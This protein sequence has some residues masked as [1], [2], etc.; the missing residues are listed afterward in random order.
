[1]NDSF[2][3]L[4]LCDALLQ[5]LPS[6]DYT[7]MT[8]IQAQS[9]PI[10]LK[11]HDIIAK[12]KT[13][14]GKTAAFGLVLLNALNVE[15][16]EVQ[17]LVLCPTRELAEQVSQALR[18][19]AR[20]IPNVKIFTLCGG[21]PSKSQLDSLKHGVHIIVGTPGR[22]QKHLDQRSLSLK[23]LQILV[24]DEMDKMLDMGFLDDIKTIIRSCP[25]QRQTLMFSATISQEIKNIAVE[26]MKEPHEVQIETAHSEQE[27]YQRFYEIKNQA[28]KFPLLKAILLHYQPS[29]SLIFCN[30]KQQTTEL[31]KM[32]VKEG[33]SAGALHGD[34]TQM[35]RDEAIICFNN[36]SCPIIVATDIA[37]RGIDIKE[38][39]AVINFELAF[40]HDVHIH[41]IG[42]TGRAGHKG[43][44]FSLV[45]PADASLIHAIGSNQ[46]HPLTWE[47]QKTLLKTSGKIPF[48][49]M[50]TLRLQA[51]RRD[52]IR[53]GDIL[54]ALTKDAGLPASTIGKI[55]IT[56]DHAYVAIQQ[57]T[58]NAAYKYFQDGKLKG[59]KIKIT[60]IKIT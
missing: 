2:L 57:T 50:V 29:S 1:M 59:R 15:L 5:N 46:A 23:K 3:N 16:L 35:A 53:P 54:G 4:P 28:D 37:A 34:L 27:I 49:E 12:S 58:I 45:T 20:L 56:D 14:S 39:S 31:V 19:L 36:H 17:A 43:L 47:T 42:R 48:P 22:I 8:P 26:F 41:R 38:L 18:R 13:G 60:G 55:T 32:L 7:A 52:K 21:T 40:D 25:K 33:F 6:L 10:M 44:A 51:G 24:L 11:G 30:T 9:L